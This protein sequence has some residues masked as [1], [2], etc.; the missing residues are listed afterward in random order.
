M[1]EQTP[2][3][4][5]DFDGTA[6]V[7][8]RKSDPRNWSKYP[9]RGLAGYSDFLKGVQSTGVEIAGVVSRR[10]DIFIRRMATARSITKLGFANFFSRSEQIV[11]KGSEAAKGRF[12][13]EQSRQT[14]V[15]ML[16]DKPHKLG[17]I[18]LGALTEPLQHPEATHHPIVLGVVSH[19]RSQEYI[20]RLVEQ[21]KA[22]TTG[23]LFVTEFASGVGPAAIIGFRLEAEALTLHVTPLQPYSEDA[24][25]AFGHKLLEVAA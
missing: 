10:P 7:I 1:S 13:A 14:T 20:E 21:A 23:D 11:H 12:I 18:L 3:L 16:E 15:G 17:A 22:R 8:A 19:G 9:L 5:S 24:G 4:W 2:R 6:V 25:A